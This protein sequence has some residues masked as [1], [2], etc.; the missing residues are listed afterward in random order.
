[1]AK[2][3]E[4]RPIAVNL[5]EYDRMERRIKRAFRKLVYEPIMSDLDRRGRLENAKSEESALLAAIKAG[6][7]TYRDGAFTGQFN[8]AVCRE[9][10]NLGAKASSKGEVWNGAKLTP[11]LHTAIRA[12]AAVFDERIK[13]IDA[14]L[15]KILPEEIAESVNLADLF[16][17]TLWK[18]DRELKQ[19]LKG[20]T[21]APVLTKDRAKRIADEWQE[22]MGLW[23][24]DFTEAEILK[25][26]KEVQASAFKGNRFEALT[27][28]IQRSYGVSANKARFLARQETSLLVTKFKETRYTEAGI[29][30]YKW[31]CVAG[32]KLHPVR[33]SH[34]ILDGKV[35]KW[36]DPPITTA[37]NE[38]TRRNNPGQDYNCR[39]AAI[40]IVNFREERN[41]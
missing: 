35:F 28:S 26:R 24:K 15:A 22:N 33:P 8:A 31:R 9:L 36:Q 16:D 17:S 13:A 38:P 4:L 7:V 14:R 18:V 40:P 27:R 39:C 41:R 20:L 32:T 12:S 29:N 23:I 6:Q 21:V 37:P 10:R 1:M 5:A 2:T 19:T 34:K 30:E 11:E 3:I 25:L